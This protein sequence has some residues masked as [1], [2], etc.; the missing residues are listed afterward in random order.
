[1]PRELLGFVT[2]RELL[3]WKE[4]LMR[5]WGYPLNAGQWGVGRLLQ[6]PVCKIQASIR[7]SRHGAPQALLKN[8]QRR[9]GPGW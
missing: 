5:D 6:R 8:I 1:M 7:G 2:L 9:A 4:V 3:T